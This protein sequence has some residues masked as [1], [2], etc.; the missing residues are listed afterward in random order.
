MSCNR[1]CCAHFYRRQ[2]G[3]SLSQVPEPLKRHILLSAD[4]GTV[5][6]H[7]RLDD[8]RATLVYD[9][10]PPRDGV[11]GYERRR[12]PAEEEVP[13]PDDGFFAALLRSLAVDYDPEVRAIEQQMAGGRRNWDWQE[14]MNRILHVRQR[15]NPDGGQ[16]QPEN[17]FPDID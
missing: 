10:V 12:A 16:P 4:I 8:S 17:E 1:K 3:Q 11:D 2:S 7:F 15:Q 14:V 9:P 6:W 13:L 5:P